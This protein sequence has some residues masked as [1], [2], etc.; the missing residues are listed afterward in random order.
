MKNQVL[1]DGFPRNPGLAHNNKSQEFQ[2]DKIKA[3][4]DKLRRLGQVDKANELL[5]QY[6]PNEVMIGELGQ[7][8]SELKDLRGD[9]AAMPIGGGGGGI[10]M[11][12]L[13]RKMSVSIE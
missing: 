2:M 8:I 13:G 7:M 10:G 5:T 1:A 12:M 6:F 9:I 3:Q 11:P 4:I